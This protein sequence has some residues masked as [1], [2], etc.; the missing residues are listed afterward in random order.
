M[1]KF[2]TYIIRCGNGSYY[3]GHSQSVL[4]RLKRHLQ[5]T[6]A[7]FTAQNKPKEVVWSKA[8][9]TEFEAVRREKQ[10]KGWSRSKKEKLISG[11]WV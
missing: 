9:D 8:F 2:F 1:N 6:G 7:R 5:K 3:T 4:G 11:L 10:I